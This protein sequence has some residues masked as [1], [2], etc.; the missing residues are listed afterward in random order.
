MT[1]A[2]L[3]AQL[4]IQPF[5]GALRLRY[6]RALLDDGELA[7]ARVQFELCGKQAASAQALIGQALIE[8]A[9]GARDK[10]LK[11]Y[12]LARQFGDFSA[13]PALEALSESARALGPSTAVDA[14]SQN[15][16]PAL[17]NTRPPVKFADVVGLEALKKTLRLQ[18]IEPFLRPGLFARFRKTAGG[19]VL[20]YG[21]PGCGKTLMAR[22][23]AGECGA[24]FFSVGVSEI[25]SMWFGES[26]S[27][28]AQLFAKAR[29]H[30]PAVLFFDE[31]DALA[32]SRAK[33][34]SEH[35][36]RIVNEFLAQLDG[37]GNDNTDILVLAAT[38]MPWDVDP[39]MKRS[40]RFSR[41]VFVPPPDATARAEMLRQRLLEVPHETLDFARVA[42]D[43]AYFSGADLDGLVDLAKERVLAEIIDGGVERPIAARDLRAALESMTPSTQDW[44]RTARNLVRYAGAD[45]SYREVESYL[46]A[47]GLN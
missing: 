4:L 47:N 3:A 40:G 42:Q 15:V 11:L 31:L 8:L 26:E 21:P 7:A 18:I 13:E 28:L 34:S 39:A 27:L 17:L 44:L 5:D 32:F 46:K 9:E 24:E 16:L 2:E 30:K 22:A 6:A 12:R 20:L 29:A 35:S 14:A 37:L 10:A 1:T 19:G 36:R 38:N 25:V 41:Q 45:S 33:A 43:L 23:V